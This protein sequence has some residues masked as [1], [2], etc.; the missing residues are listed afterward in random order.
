MS[1]LNSF[2]TEEQRLGIRKGLNV[3]KSILFFVLKLSFIPIAFACLLGYYF[4]KKELGKDSSYATTVSFVESKKINSPISSAISSQLNL[5]RGGQEDSEGIIDAIVK[6]DRIF[7]DAFFSGYSKFDSTFLINKVADVYYP[8]VPTRFSNKREIDSMTTV[9]RSL[10]KSIFGLI[11]NEKNGLFVFES[12]ETV[13]KI[14][15]TTKDELLTYNLANNIYNALVNFYDSNKTKSIDNSLEL[16]IRKR[17]STKSVLKSLNR[18]LAKHNDKSGLYRTPSKNLDQVNLVREIYITE[19]QY[20]Q[21]YAQVEAFEITNTDGSESYF[22]KLNYPILPLTKSKKN[23]L[24]QT[25][26]GGVIGLVLGFV[27]IVLIFVLI[28]L[29]QFLRALNKEN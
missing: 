6:S 25:V 12:S 26:I 8:D 19:M 15:V 24:K 2:L 7:L 18:K 13:Q 29:I 20:N 17:D 16:L 9:E 27:L 1:L 28:E 3:A 22:Q 4:R 5:I 23:V 21:L 14:S 11:T 10:Y